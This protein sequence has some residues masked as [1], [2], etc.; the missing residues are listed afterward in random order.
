MSPASLTIGLG[1]TPY[2]Q[3][4]FEKQK[5][6]AAWEREVMGE[7]FSYSLKAGCARRSLDTLM[8]YQIQQGILERKPE[9][10]ELFFPETFH[11]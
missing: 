11:F 7:E 6:E 1:S 3:A 4:L 5:S 10:E 8:D 9:L 2:T